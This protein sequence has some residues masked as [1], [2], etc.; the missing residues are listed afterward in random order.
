MSRFVQFVLLYWTSSKSNSLTRLKALL[1]SSG[2]PEPYYQNILECT[3]G[4]IFIGTPH[5]GSDA[6][7]WASVL[8]NFAKLATHVNR[9][10]TDVLE[11]GSQV[12]ASVQQEF[13]RLLARR[14]ADK[15]SEVKIFCMFEELPVFAIG[16]VS[17]V[18]NNVSS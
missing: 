6:T 4:I 15:K 10:I 7:K 13:H 12:L 16:M 18:H 11:S 2:A 3:V 17:A 14:A 9:D 1:I 8:V 5:A